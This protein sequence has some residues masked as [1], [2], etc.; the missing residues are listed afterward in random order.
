[1]KFGLFAALVLMLA[2][3]QAAADSIEFGSLELSGMWTRATPPKAP[4]AGGYLTITNQGDEPDRLVA[5]ASSG[6]GKAVLHVM[7]LKDDVM[8]MRPAQ[9]GIEVPAG[10]SATLVPDGSHIM[11][12]DLKGPL[13]PGGRLPVTLTFAKGGSVDVLFDILPIGSSGPGIGHAHEMT[14]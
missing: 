5:V 10:G 13:K 14:E 4:T 9:D 2:A 12:I 6:A 7:Q 8:T 1:M 3:S 11:F